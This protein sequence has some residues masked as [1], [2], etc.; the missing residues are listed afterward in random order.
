MISEIAC[1]IDKTISAA[2]LLGSMLAVPY[3]LQWHALV[4]SAYPKRRARRP[5]YIS[6]LKTYAQN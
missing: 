2:S 3:D 6:T 4:L 1:G 5:N